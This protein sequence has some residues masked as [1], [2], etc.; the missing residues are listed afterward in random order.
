[1][2]SQERVPPSGNVSSGPGSRMCV[3]WVVMADSWA[4]GSIISKTAWGLSLLCSLW[5]W[6]LVRELV[7]V[8]RPDISG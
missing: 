2:T 4:G 8:L 6:R 3:V 7:C 5:W 1:M